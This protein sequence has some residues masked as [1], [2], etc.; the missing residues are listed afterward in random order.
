[1]VPQTLPALDEPQVPNDAVVTATHPGEFRSPEKIAHA[2]IHLRRMHCRPIQSNL[3]EERIRSTAPRLMTIL[4]VKLRVGGEPRR[5]D[6]VTR[7]PLVVVGSDPYEL[8]DL[9]FAK[10]LGLIRSTGR[11]SKRCSTRSLTA[12]LTSAV[13]P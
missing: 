11:N 10:P 5:F 12:S 9:K 13:V 7:P 2:R 8:I 3:D 4:A 1:M 6:C